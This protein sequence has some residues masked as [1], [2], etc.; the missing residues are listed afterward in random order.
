MVQAVDVVGV[1]MMRLGGGFVVVGLVL[2]EMIE[3][4]GCIQWMIEEYNYQNHSVKMMFFNP[5]RLSILPYLYLQNLPRY[6]HSTPSNPLPISKHPLHNGY[7]LFCNEVELTIRANPLRQPRDAPSWSSA[8]LSPT[9][10]YLCINN[11]VTKE[12]MHL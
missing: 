2:F 12:K 3:W 5:I 6:Y 10:I 7:P 8:T 9:H 4:F 1:A 11:L